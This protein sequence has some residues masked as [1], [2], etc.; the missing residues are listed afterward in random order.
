MRWWIEDRAMRRVAANQEQERM[1][2]ST[3]AHKDFAD[4]YW[5]RMPQRL[6]YGLQKKNMRVNFRDFK[7]IKALV[8]PVDLAR[9]PAFYAVDFVVQPNLK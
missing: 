7:V 9:Q 3:I 8:N 1:F 5:E 4:S 6:R 2:F